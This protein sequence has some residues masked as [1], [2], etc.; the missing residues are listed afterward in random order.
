VAREEN[1]P[2]PVPTNKKSPQ[3]TV[4]VFSHQWWIGNYE[5]G[6]GKNK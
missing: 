5:V 3:K 2:D 6:C 1:D 4:S